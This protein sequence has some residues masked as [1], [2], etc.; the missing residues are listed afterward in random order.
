MSCGRNPSASFWI[1]KIIVQLR[2]CCRDCFVHQGQVSVGVVRRCGG[3]PS[4]YAY[5]RD[6]GKALLLGGW[7]CGAIAAYDATREPA[8]DRHA[9]ESK[10]GEYARFYTT[11]HHWDKEMLYG[12]TRNI[13]SEERK[14]KKDVEGRVRGVRD[15]VKRVQ[16][17]NSR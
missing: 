13:Q 10:H 5:N 4:K 9:D 7:N 3:H 16:V 15:G 14:R 6:R 8:K 1:R 12:N 17:E 2:V 11:S